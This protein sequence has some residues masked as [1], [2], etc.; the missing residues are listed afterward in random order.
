MPVDS[1]DMAAVV[2]ADHA[3]VLHSW[4]AQRSPKAP[5]VA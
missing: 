4:S 3:H 5:V 2:D 1:L